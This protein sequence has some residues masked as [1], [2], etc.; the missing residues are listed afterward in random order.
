MSAGPPEPR[1]LTREKL[2]AMRHHGASHR[3]L[4][5]FQA[6]RRTPMDDQPAGTSAAPRRAPGSGLAMSAP[7]RFVVFGEALTDFIQESPGRWRSVPGGAC[8]NVA[9]AAARLG[10]P[11]GYAGAVSRDG[12]GDDLWRLAAEAGLDMRFTQR[13][14]K[15]PLLAMVVSK[16][17]PQYFFAGDDA[18]D[19]NF[20]LGALPAGWLDEAELVHFGSISL[21]RQPH[22][23]RL[24][25]LAERVRAAGKRICFDP[26]WRNLMEDPGYPDTLAR[27][28]RVADYVKVSVEDLAR[29]FPGAGDR[30]LDRLRALAPRAAVLVTDGAA[31]MRLLAGGREVVQPAFPVVVADTVGAGD[32]SLAGWMASLLAAPGAPL[33]RHVAFAAATAA[34][35]CGHHG[36]Y[37]PARAEVEAVLG[38]G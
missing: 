7:A 11:T 19:V 36:A 1:A 2:A 27:L 4:P 3:G 25:A 38:R 30:A 15:A 28:C 33:E 8:W 26:N 9:R 18:A 29:L 20:D 5:R 31:G 34:V 35:V 21:V 10:V 24:V 17:P 6:R 14:A 16:D 12:F 32:A 37:A 23:A 13:V 22:A